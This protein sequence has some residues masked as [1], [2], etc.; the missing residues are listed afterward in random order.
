MLDVGI[1]PL[2]MT[3]EK[4][5]RKDLDTFVHREKKNNAISFDVNT[6]TAVA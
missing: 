1:L 5:L 4:L 3:Q 2:K 6:D